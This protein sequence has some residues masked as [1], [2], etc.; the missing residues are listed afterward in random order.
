MYDSAPGMAEN[1]ANYMQ[2]TIKLLKDSL[3]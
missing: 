3:P 1:F 2:S